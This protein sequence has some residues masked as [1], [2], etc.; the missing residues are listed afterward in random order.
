MLYTVRLSGSFEYLTNV[1]TC[2]RTR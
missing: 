2:A 1:R